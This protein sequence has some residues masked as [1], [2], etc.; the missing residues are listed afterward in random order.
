LDIAVVR[1]KGRALLSTLAKLNRF[2]TSFIRF[3]DVLA[4]KGDDLRF[5]LG[6]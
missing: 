2:P 5:G 4:Q 3:L 6:R 1:K